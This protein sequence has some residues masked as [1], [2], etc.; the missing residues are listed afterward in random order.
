MAYN[1]GTPL[2]F[3]VRLVLCT[4]PAHPFHTRLVP[5][6]VHR[7]S[8]RTRLT[9]E[10]LAWHWSHWFS[11]R[12]STHK[13]RVRHTRP[14]QLA[15]V[16]RRTVCPAGCGVRISSPVRFGVRRCLRGGGR[17][18][19]RI[20]CP[21]GRGVRSCS[22]LG[23]SFSLSGRRG[24]LS[25]SGRRGVVRGTRPLVAVE[26]FGGALGEGCE[27]EFDEDGL[28]VETPGGVLR[29]TGVPRS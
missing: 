14:V 5:S 18:I 13:R 9:L 21:T 28:C 3:L 22:G 4:R 17:G 6:R 26:E 23:G 27:A 11:G 10:P 25:F 29:V 7:G 19:S 12:H 16:Q 20:F 8:L 24:V 2:L 15:T 1:I